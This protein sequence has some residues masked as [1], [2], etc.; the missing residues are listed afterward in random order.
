MGRLAF[1]LSA[2]ILM[3][4]VAAG[5]IAV[6]VRQGEPEY[7][8]SAKQ[9]TPEP[10]QDRDVLSAPMQDSSPA[11]AF[12]LPEEPAPAA[13]VVVSVCGAV[14]HPGVYRFELGDRVHD[15]I[16]RAD[17]VVDAADLSDINIAAKLLDDTTL[18]VPFRLY[19]ETAG[20]TL[21]ARRGLSAAEANPARYTRSGWVY[22][23]PTTVD[24]SAPTPS[25]E[26][27]PTAAAPAAPAQDGMVH[28]NS[29]TL[30]EL[31]QLPG[32]G[33]KTAE[34]IDAYRQAQPFRSVDELREVHGIG[35]KK[36]E[37]VRHLVTVD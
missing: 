18:Y 7:I 26:T 28:L 5:A 8:G 17:G 12:A 1:F 20:T 35:E 10:E 37:A 15:G 25:A 6:T 31:Q 3:A 22:G 34:K 11:D 33:P 4:I 16:E 29:A 30:A 2:G 27:P 21:V 36:L 23:A 13:D 24:E 32:I 9:E 14:V 19:R